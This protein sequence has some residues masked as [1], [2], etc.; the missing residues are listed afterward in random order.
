MPI[1][2]NVFKLHLFLQKNK[3]KIKSI[4]GNKRELRVVESINESKSDITASELSIERGKSYR[5]K[6]IHPPLLKDM[7]LSF[8][9][10]I[11]TPANKNTR[12][13]EFLSH[14]NTE[15]ELKLPSIAHFKKLR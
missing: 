10:S 7:N 6:Q 9:K 8:G 14:I 2:L 15:R 11:L 3:I 1:N 13:Y 12:N 5:T 4:F